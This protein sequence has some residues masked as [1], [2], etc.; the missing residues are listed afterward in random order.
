M[1]VDERYKFPGIMYIWTQ[2]FD[3]GAKSVSVIHGIPLVR[4]TLFGFSVT[5]VSLRPVRYVSSVRFFRFLV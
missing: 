4:F 2:L 5:S 3:V 1:F